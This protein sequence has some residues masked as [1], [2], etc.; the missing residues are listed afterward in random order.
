MERAN[1]WWMSAYLV[2][3][4]LSHVLRAWRWRYL[5]DPVK[6]HIGLR[7]LFSGVMIGYFFNNILPRAGEL[8]RPYAIGKLESVPKS[9]ALGTIVV[10]RIIDVLTFLLLVS[11]L[12]V[13]YDGPLLESFPWLQDAGFLITAVTVGLL[14]VMIVFMMRRDWTNAVVQRSARIL[15]A[16]LIGRTRPL[17]HSFLDGFSFLKRPWHVIIVAAG[18]LIVWLL[19]IIMVYLAFFSFGIGNLGFRAAAVV[20][21][22]SSIGVAIPT[23]GGTGSYHTLTSQSLTRLFGV[24]PVVAL[25]YATVTHAVGYI[26]VT[27]VGAYFLL[28]DHMHVGEA[29]GGT[30]HDT[31]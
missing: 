28:R 12:P 18:S 26:G 22:I 30:Q 9:F 14:A 19:Y 31:E 2:C 4:L 1:Y 25:G 10:E 3:L 6:P 7:N 11:L 5:L 29:V 17:I 24:D 8:A 20:Q 13:L 27:L 23:P 16:W 21:A 15:P